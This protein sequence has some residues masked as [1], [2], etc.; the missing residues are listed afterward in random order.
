MGQRGL[1][2][3]GSERRLS[4]SGS[5]RSHH[6]PRINNPES[7]FQHP[8]GSLG[9]GEDPGPRVGN[10]HRALPALPLPRMRTD[11]GTTPPR[12]V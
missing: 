2:P 1:A 6:H 5:P 7:L 4:L 11:R 12:N 9:L 10:R 3:F 8:E